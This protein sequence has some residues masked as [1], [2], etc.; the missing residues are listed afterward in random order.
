MRRK[1]TGQQKTTSKIKDLDSTK[2]IITLSVNEL[3]N[4]LKGK[5]L[6]R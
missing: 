5:R 4:P 2:S 6:Q 1:K 3:T